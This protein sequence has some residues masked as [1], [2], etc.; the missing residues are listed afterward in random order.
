MQSDF[1]RPDKPV[2]P[3]S[4]L[5]HKQRLGRLHSSEGFK[6]SILSQASDAA[7]SSKPTLTEHKRKMKEL[8]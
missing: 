5:T 6:H 7:S 3:A 8:S 1:A 4:V 2:E